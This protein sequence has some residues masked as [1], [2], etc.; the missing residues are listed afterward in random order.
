M[1]CKYQR[2]FDIIKKFALSK[3]S[4]IVYTAK[5]INRSKNVKIKLNTV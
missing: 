3:Q 5:R 4:L 2:F 1:S